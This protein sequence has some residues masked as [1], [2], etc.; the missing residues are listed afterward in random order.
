[1]NRLETIADHQ[2]RLRTRD[3]VFGAW[4][5]FLALTAIATVYV[6]L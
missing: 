4:V 6:A 1:M 5:V 3:L 2:R